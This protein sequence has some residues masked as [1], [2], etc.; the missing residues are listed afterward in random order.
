M[1]YKQTP[2]QKRQKKSKV[3]FALFGVIILFI[4]T[5]SKSTPQPT[6]VNITIPNGASVSSIAQILKDQNVIKSELLFKTYVKSVEKQNTLLA[7]NYQLNQGAEFE[8]IIK[9]LSTYQPQ[10]QKITIPE[11]Y[12]TKQIQELAPNFCLD[13]CNVTHSL[14]QIPSLENLRSFEGL[15]FPDT[16]FMDSNN[17]NQNQLLTKML[18]NFENKLPKDYEQKLQNLPKK[19]LYSTIIVASLIE[20]EVRTNKDK[21][22]VSGI[23]WT[24]FKSDWSL[25]IDA[26]LLYKKDNNIITYADL[27]K[28]DPYNLRKN[29]G[30]PPTPICNPGYESTYAALNPK[31]SDY[32]FYLS[33]K[34]D[35]S[36]VFA[37]TNEQH[38][39]N[40]QRY[41]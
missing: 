30:L 4:I 37:E 32:W 27:Q 29:K 20:K 6:T 28:D 9:I 2:R 15:L 24:R 14:L 10:I 23:I 19:D 41:L 26:A 25:G 40:K 35:G 39:Q 12:T 8:E 7:G 18:D 34:S 3:Y 11:G 1:R 36:T 17:L 5:S 38:N 33:K 21:Q 13:N 16:Y 22:L 31:Y